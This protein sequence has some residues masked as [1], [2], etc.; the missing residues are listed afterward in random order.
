MANSSSAHFN[1]S[2][3]SNWNNIVLGGWKCTHSC[4]FCIGPKRTRLH[5]MLT[6]DF[7]LRDFYIYIYVRL[8]GAHI[9]AHH[10]FCLFGW[11]VYYTH[12]ISIPSNFRLLLVRFVL[13]FFLH[14]CTT[15]SVIDARYFWALCIEPMCQCVHGNH[16]SAYARCSLI[17]WLYFTLLHFNF[18]QCYVVSP[19]LVIH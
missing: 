15:S 6:L 9:C 7:A 12:L 8:S 4:L 19:A 10:S 16:V 14:F 3:Q 11:C 18:V 1:K 17:R 5:I 13:F 2:S